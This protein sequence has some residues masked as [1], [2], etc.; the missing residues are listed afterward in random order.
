MS[1][2]TRFLLSGFAWLALISGLDAYLNVNWT[3]IANGH[4]RHA[5]CFH[6][7]HQRFST[8]FHAPFFHDLGRAKWKS[9]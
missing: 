5:T 3:S 1:L 6:P 9:V 8:G 4:P 2:K 7:A